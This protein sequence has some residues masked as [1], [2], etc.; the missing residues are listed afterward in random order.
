MKQI[1]EKKKK[2]SRR[3]V[4]LQQMIRIIE[5]YTVTE[6]TE[7]KE[8]SKNTNEKIPNRK[9]QSPSAFKHDLRF[10]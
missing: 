1:R 5:V 9:C 6:T 10:D 3:F 7:A 4:K 2:T 8:T